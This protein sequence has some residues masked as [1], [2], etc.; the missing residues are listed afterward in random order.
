[1]REQKFWSSVKKSD[2]CWAWTGR[3]HKGYGRYGGVQAH[4]VAYELV[5]G[6]ISA[7]LELDHTC[8]NPLCVNPDHLEP[9]TR[10]ENMRRRYATQS[11]CK[12]GHEFTPENTYTGLGVRQCR[13]CQR[14]AVARYRA[15]KVAS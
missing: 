1:M 8:R 7:G 4:R 9:V 3:T 12:R 13:A 2:A 6:P 11:H 14:E 15:R 10:S 5:I